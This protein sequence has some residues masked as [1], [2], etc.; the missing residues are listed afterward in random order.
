MDLSSVFSE[1][2]EGKKTGQLLIKFE[3]EE[4][5]CKVYIENGN[6]VHIA[7]G[8]KSPDETMIYIANRQPVE[9]HF[10]KGVH[11]IKKAGAPLNNRLR[12]LAEGGFTGNSNLDFNAKDSFDCSSAHQK[13]KDEKKKAISS[14]NASLDFDAKD[15]FEKNPVSRQKDDDFPDINLNENITEG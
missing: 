13:D 2:F 5:L 4:N 10:I 11:P 8:S 14:F 1:Y 7:I 15:S 9:A 3:G 12:K 6:A